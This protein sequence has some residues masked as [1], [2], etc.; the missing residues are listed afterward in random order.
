[1]LVNTR[2][3]AATIDLAALAPDI[4]PGC[5]VLRLD[6]TTPD[7]V[8]RETGTAH[9]AITGYGVVVLSDDARKTVI[10]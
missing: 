8:R 10:D 7:C 1:V 4:L 9:V 6:Q 3:R 2:P 5:D